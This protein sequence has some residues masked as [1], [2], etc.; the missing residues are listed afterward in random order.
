MNWGFWLPLMV[1]MSSMIPGLLIFLLPE[2][3]AVT[4]TLLNLGGALLKLALIAVMLWGVYYDRGYE[5]RITLLPGFDLVM[6]AS[7]L[8]M[9]FVVLSGLLWLLT[10]IYAIGYLE[11][12][13]NKSRFFGFFSICVSATTGIALAG[14]LFSFVVFYELL[15]LAT[16]PLVVHRGTPESLKAG[17]VYLAYT[18]A[19][20]AM[21]MLGVIWLH[22][23]VGPFDFV[24]GG[25]LAPYQAEHA[26]L[27]T[28]IFFLLIAGLGVKASLVPLHGWLPLAMVAPAPVSALLHAVAVVKAGAFGIVRVVYD[29]Y[30]VRVVEV[31]GLDEILAGLA[32]LTILYGSVLALHQ[33]NLKRRLAYSTVSQVS[34]IVLGV[35]IAGPLAT[36]GGIVHLVHQGLMKITLFFCAG[37]LGETIGVHRIS[38]MNGVGRRMPLTM[39]AF[40]IAAL[41]MIGIPPLAGFVSKWYLGVG[42]LE[43]GENWVIAV[44]VASSLLN[45]A[46]FLPIINAAWF[47]PPDGPWPKDVRRGRLETMPTLLWPPVITACAVVLAGVLANMPF[48]PLDWVKLIANRLYLP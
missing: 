43:V 7:A 2:E 40:T 6:H 15:T 4:R 13:Q 18:L 33:D 39:A 29:V 41:A 9:F 10:T 26:Q 46:Y 25:A 20:G 8:A 30:G 24:E 32:A 34:Y 5:T 12:G 37:N 21:L 3:R 1:V 42:A 17:R 36:I 22:S 23:L 19:G 28:V 35:A 14:N 11:G 27:L 47:N 44:L 38:A 31:L 45:A 48:S 16:Y